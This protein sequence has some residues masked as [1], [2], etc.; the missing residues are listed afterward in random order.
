MYEEY[1][2]ENDIREIT[3]DERNK[4]LI[5]SVITAKIELNTANINFENA[6]EE[7]IDYYTYL[8]KANQAKLDY[9][10]KKVKS[11][12]LE[13]DMINEIE[14]RRDKAV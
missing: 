1:I 7:L 12:G 6:E 5:R 13:L 10:V 9:L 3:S 8:I 2:R 4:E 11:E 14:M